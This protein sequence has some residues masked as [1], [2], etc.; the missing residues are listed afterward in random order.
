MRG[1]IFGKEDEAA[2]YLVP[3][4][5]RYVVAEVRYLICA[6]LTCGTAVSLLPPRLALLIFSLCYARAYLGD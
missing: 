3:V 6:G 2:T 1:E 5:A 4:D